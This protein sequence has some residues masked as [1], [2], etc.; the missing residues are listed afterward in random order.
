MATRLATAPATAPDSPASEPWVNRRVYI[1]RPPGPNTT[2]RV[3]SAR[4]RPRGARI[5]DISLGGIALL[6]RQ[7]LR[8][9]ARLLIQ[10][11]NEI[12]GIRYDLAAR[13]VH[14]TP[15]KRDEWILGCEFSRT[16][17]EPELQNLL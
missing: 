16:L 1:R 2:T 13:V 7:R 3:A 9:G 8:V 15:K 17:S 11:K 14:T 12:L 4:S 10:V 6:S 5:Q